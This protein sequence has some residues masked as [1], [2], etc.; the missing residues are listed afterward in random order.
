[1]AK[2]LDLSQKLAE[3]KAGLIPNRIET[4]GFAEDPAVL[5]MTEARQAIIQRDR[6]VVKR[7][8]LTEFIGAFV[9][10]PERGL[11]R[12]SIYD[13]SD[14]GMAFDTEAS[15]GHFTH[16]EEVA[17]RVY[18]NHKTYFPFVIK[19]TN[20]RLIESEGVV[21]HG[22]NYVKGTINDVALNHFVK[23]IETISASLKTDDGDILVSN[24]L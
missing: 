4:E 1:M 3:R 18:L 16:D 24:I 21:R 19:V 5:D 15:T 12:V 23:F 22:A 8:M 14:K 17:I 13:I 20:T 6:R 7:T 11:Y 2:I 9:V 10:L